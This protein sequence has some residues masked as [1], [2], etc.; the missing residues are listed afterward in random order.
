MNQP[1]C[2]GP[3]HITTGCM[4]TNKNLNFGQRKKNIL[5]NQLFNST[6]IDSH[7][8]NVVWTIPYVYNAMTLTPLA[9]FPM[10]WSVLLHKHLTDLR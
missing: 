4:H 3:S 5:H 2:L 9:Q 8:H 1:L 7:Q 6:N 10:K